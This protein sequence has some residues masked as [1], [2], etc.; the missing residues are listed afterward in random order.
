MR[1]APRKT[2]SEAEL[3]AAALRALMRRAHST[4]ELRIYLERRA[5]EPTPVRH[6]LARLKQEKLI[7]DARYALD[8]ARARA[9]ARRQGGRRIA[10]ELRKRGV[11]DRHI[12]AAIA[13]VFADFDEAA[14][15]RKVIERRTR[16]ARGPSDRRP[17]GGNPDGTPD[18]TFDR[19]FD[20]KKMASLYRTLLRAGFDPG[21]IRRELATMGRSPRSDAPDVV[22]G[23]EGE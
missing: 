3:Y 9:S 20:R 22:P 6:I 11:P 10:M 19:D 13:Q 16:S 2:S 23:D 4:F 7:D 12:D 17:P 8:F 14:I 15:V 21:V 5:V 1:S 18:G